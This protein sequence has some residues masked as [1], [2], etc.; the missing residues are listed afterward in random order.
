MALY[1]ASYNPE[2]GLI[3]ALV[4]LSYCR[5]FERTKSSEEGKEKYRTV[6]LIPKNTEEGKIQMAAI[7][8]GIKDLISKTKEWNNMSPVR[9]RD[10]MGVGAKGRWVV[11]DGDMYY[12]SSGNVRDGYEGQYYLRLTNDR[13]IKVRGRNGQELHEEEKHDLFQSGHWAIALFRI[14]AVTDQK[15]GGNG[16]FSTLDALQFYKRDTV[17]GGG[18]VSDDEFDDLG[19]EEDGGTTSSKKTPAA[20]EDDL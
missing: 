6:G 10:M 18:G 14:Y 11:F 1:Q 3:K 16:L 7:N 9:L 17:F 12:D 5:I 15:R 20:V 2:T 8:A 13:P 4:R 19:D